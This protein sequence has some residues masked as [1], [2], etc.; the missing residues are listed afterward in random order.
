MKNDTET[1][2]I[3]AEIGLGFEGENTVHEE[4]AA[5]RATSVSIACGLH[6]GDP[7][8]M[9]RCVDFAVKHNLIVGA[10]IGLP[11]LMGL[12]DMGLAPKKISPKKSYAQTLFQIGALSAFA[13][14]AET[15][16]QQVKLYGPL[17]EASIK[18]SELADAITSALVN[19]A[20]D[21]LVLGPANSELLLAAK[22]TGLP[23]AIEIPIA[24]ALSDGGED[25]LGQLAASVTSGDVASISIDSGQEYAVMKL[26]E[27]RRALHKAGISPAPLV[28]SAQS[29]PL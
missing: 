21:L 7:D 17:Y 8:T 6:G 28:T 13:K 15:S 22:K 29:F 12:G 20:P 26:D 18:D 16:L 19:V 1:I 24:D 4:K 23:T 14:A 25:Q 10:S 2:D 3:N 9:R 27:L 5:K 11:N